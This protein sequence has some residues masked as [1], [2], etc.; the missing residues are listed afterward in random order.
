LAFFSFFRENTIEFPGKS[1]WMNLIN[2][3]KAKQ[4]R[5]DLQHHPHPIF[6]NNF[7]Y[8]Y[9]GD[10]NEMMCEIDCEIVFFF[11]GFRGCHILE[12]NFLFFFSFFRF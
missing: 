8:G 9:H 11:F 10:S 3:K 1:A 12:K 7:I 4:R 6:G 5:L 2:E